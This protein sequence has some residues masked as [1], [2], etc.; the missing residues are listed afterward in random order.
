MNT[1]YELWTIVDYGTVSVISKIMT[2]NKSDETDL[3][4]L[5]FYYRGFIMIT[6]S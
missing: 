5:N 6:I 3:I 1:E 2:N 4:I